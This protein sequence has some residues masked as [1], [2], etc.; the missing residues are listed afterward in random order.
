MDLLLYWFF[1]EFIGCFVARLTIPVLSFGRAYVHPF[2]SPP[3]QF[4]W[5]GY[6]RDESGR[7]VVARDA[8]GFI[9]FMII[10]IVFLAIVLIVRPF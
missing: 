7:M 4:N 2:G 8:A 5:L 6:R 1:F 10:V 3:G 9:G